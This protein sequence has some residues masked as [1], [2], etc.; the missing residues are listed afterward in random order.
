MLKHVESVTITQLQIWNV[1][2]TPE[3]MCM[4]LSKIPGGTRDNWSKRVLLIRRKQGKE[5]EMV[6]C[7]GLVNDENLIV[8]DPVLK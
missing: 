4:V 1:L 6:D 8:S 2:D 5:P 3:I 7:I